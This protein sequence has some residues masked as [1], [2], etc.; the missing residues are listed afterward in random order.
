MSTERQ[1]SRAMIAAIAFMG[2]TPGLRLLTSVRFTNRLVKV[3]VVAAGL[4]IVAMI[5]AGLFAPEGSVLMTVFWA[6]L[7]GHFAWSFIFAGWILSGGAIAE[8]TA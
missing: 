6:W 1:F 7:I 8:P 3:N 4:T 5:A 2:H